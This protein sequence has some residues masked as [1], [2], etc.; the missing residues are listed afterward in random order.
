MK[1]FFNTKSTV[2]RV[3]I[4]SLLASGLVFASTFAVN[5]FVP[6]PTEASNCCEGAEL[7]T[8]PDGNSSE[9]QRHCTGR[10]GSITASSC[11]C[12]HSNCP[13]GSCSCGGSSKSCRSTCG[14]CSCSSIC[15]K[16]SFSCGTQGGTCTKNP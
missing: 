14:T 8:V 10:K 15:D 12:G 3:M 7:A 5:M 2:G 1:A 16:G 6:T 4:V 13:G 11:S 9:L